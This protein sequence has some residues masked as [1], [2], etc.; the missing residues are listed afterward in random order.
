MTIKREQ[1]EASKKAA[2]AARSK[3]DHNKSSAPFKDRI[4]AE[5]DAKKAA[6]GS[7]NA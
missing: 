5:A 7:S 6:E 1:Y 3:L 4:R 2:N